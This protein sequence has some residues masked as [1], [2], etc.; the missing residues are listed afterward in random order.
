M[1][2]W[3]HGKTIGFPSFSGKTG[4]PSLS[5][6]FPSFFLHC[7]SLFPHFS[8]IFPS[9]FLHFSFI[10]LHCSLTFPSFFPHFSFIFPSFFP[11]TN[12]RTS[13]VPRL[14]PGAGCV[15]HSTLEPPPGLSSLS[16]GSVPWQPWLFKKCFKKIW[17]QYPI[18]SHYFF[19]ISHYK[20]ISRYR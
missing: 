3:N 20:R 13:G 18:I 19:L 16:E 5:L 4:F 10:V 8:F 14:C 2:A 12:P 6:I 7:P 1:M 11:P 15:S 17:F 9:F